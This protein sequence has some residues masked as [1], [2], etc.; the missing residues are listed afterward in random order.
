MNL[1]MLLDMAA[2]AFG[3]RAAVSCGAR[4][5]SYAELRAAAQALAGELRSGSYAHAA[6]LDTNGIA[7]PVTLFAAAYAGLP[8][9][10][11]NYRLTAPELTALL[12]RVAPVWLAAAPEQLARSH[13]APWHHRHR[14]APARHGQPSRWRCRVPRRP[15]IP[16]RWRDPA[17]Y[18]R[19]YGCAQGGRAAA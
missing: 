19:H 15:V 7:A 12:E 9:V 8:Y 3:E 1:A 10:P 11:L 4:T 2:E 13:P 5:V 18:E 16:R 17:V 14:C 6:L